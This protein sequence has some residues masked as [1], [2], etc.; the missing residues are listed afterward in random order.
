MS[1]RYREYAPPERLRPY[2]ECFWSVET[3]ESIPDYSVLPDGCVDIVFSPNTGL[4]IVGAMTHARNFAIAS[5]S[6]QVGVRFRP[7]MALGFVR[8]PGSQTTDQLVPLAA[9][10]GAKG[11]ALE[12][13]M[14]DAEPGGDESR[15]SKRSWWIRL[16]PVWSRRSRHTLWLTMAR[17]ASMTWRSMPE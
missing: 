5:D 17:C 12:A 13:R 9:M 10:W 14:N 4:E 11:R 1:A 16:R 3:S 15:C 2:V 7:G 8:A 6:P